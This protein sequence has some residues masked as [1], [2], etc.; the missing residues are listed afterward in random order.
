MWWLGLRMMYCVSRVIII[1]CS[2][3][4]HGG[5][6]GCISNGSGGVCGACV[7]SLARYDT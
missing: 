7:T 1:S 5:H 2:G 6:V 4:G 3:G